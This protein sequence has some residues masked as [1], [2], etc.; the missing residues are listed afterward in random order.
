MAQVAVFADRV[1]KDWDLFADYKVGKQ[2]Q[3]FRKRRLL[4][5][6]SPECV[7]HE[8]EVDRTFETVDNTHNA[9]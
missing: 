5:E 2:E 8:S 7:R 9:H 4:D 6:T 3:D 1:L